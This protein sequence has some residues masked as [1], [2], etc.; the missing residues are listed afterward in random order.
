MRTLLGH[1]TAQARLY[2]KEPRQVWR[3]E[4]TRDPKLYTALIHCGQLQ[5]CTQGIWRVHWE[6][7]T[8]RVDQLRGGSKLPE[9]VDCEVPEQTA[10]K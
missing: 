9:P 3:E 4:A 5:I 6:S 1:G 2:Q 8:V 7:P 10:S